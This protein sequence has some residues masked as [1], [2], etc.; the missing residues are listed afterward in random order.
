MGTF[1]DDDS[2]YL[3]REKLN[4]RSKPPVALNCLN[5]ADVLYRGTTRL[6]KKNPYRETAYETHA[7][8]QANQKAKQRPHFKSEF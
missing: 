7:G 5:S 2:T 1:M 6:V 3:I 4:P 8:V